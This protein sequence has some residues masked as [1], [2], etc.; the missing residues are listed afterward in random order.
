MVDGTATITAGNEYVDVTHGLGF[1]PDLDK[2]YVRPKDDLGGRSFY[3]SDADVT[4]FRITISSMDTEDHIFGWSYPYTALGEGY[5]SVTQVKDSIRSIKKE[6]FGFTTDTEYE[7]WLATL[8]ERASRFIDGYCERPETYFLS[9][10]IELTEYYDGVGSSPPSGMHEFSEEVTSWE[11]QAGTIFTK[12]RPIVSIP[13]IHE[14]KVAIGDTDDWQEITA[15]RWFKH[16]EIAFASGS[17]PAKGRKNVRIV[18]NTGYTAKPRSIEMACCSLVVN[19]LHKQISDKT[20]G[21]TSFT[22]PTAINFGIPQVFSSDIKAMLN[23]Y[24]MSGFGEM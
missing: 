13:T 10:G 15:F 12:H 2:M 9:G 24:K 8:I 4:T 3:T 5:C 1:I 7:N 14:N 20:A 11:E 21:F 16:G 19:L 18:Y 22:R 17:I 6:E 23:R